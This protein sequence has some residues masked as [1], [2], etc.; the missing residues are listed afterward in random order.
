MH[1]E[2]IGGL[3]AL[4]AR[5]AGRSVGIAL[6][7]GGARAFSHI[8]VL[9]ELERAGIRIH[10]VAGTSVGS[11]IGG[12]YAAGWSVDEMELALRD[13]FV[14]RNPLGDYGLPKYALSRGGRITRAVERVFGDLRAEALPRELTVM[15]TDIMSREV[16][17]LSEGLLRDITRASAAVPGLLPPVRIG[18]RILVDGAVTGNLPVLPLVAEGVGP[19]IAVNLAVG[20][21]EGPR[22]SADGSARPARMP[23]LGETMMRTLLFASG[24][25]D[26][27]AAEAADIVVTTQTRNIGLLEFHQIDEAIVAGRAAGRAV[28]A[29][30]AERGL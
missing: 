16:V 13:E 20:A 14:H 6:A 25:T 27:R 17:A 10:R 4:G 2:E 12:A 19:V 30:L 1:V 29:S 8:G 7:G 26:R 9:R 23:T 15:A 18:D 24:D 5:L 22:A 11:Y 28:V 21:G 3:D